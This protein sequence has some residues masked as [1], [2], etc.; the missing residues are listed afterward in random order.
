MRALQKAALVLFCL[1]LS[2]L[3]ILGA[4]VTLI[5]AAVKF[6]W[7]GPLLLMLYG[8]GNFLLTLF[9]LAGDDPRIPR[10]SMYISAVAAADLIGMWALFGPAG[11]ESA[12][13]LFW[14]LMVF[15]NWLAIRK[16]VDLRAPVSTEA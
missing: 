7:I 8:M 1:G 15:F 10:F 2:I 13:V 14:C 16:L 12:W 11:Q 9:A 6:Y 5:F 3:C 4:G